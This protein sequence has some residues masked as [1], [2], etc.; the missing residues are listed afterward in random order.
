MELEK[1][2][3][4]KITVKICNKM[5]EIKT[6]SRNEI[7]NFGQSKTT[8]INRNLEKK[9]LQCQYCGKTLSSPQNLRIHERLH[10][11][12]KPYQCKYCEKK[13]PTSSVLRTHHQ[14]HSGTQKPIVE[15]NYCGKEVKNLTKHMKIHT[16]IK[17]DSFKCEIC[18]KVF[19][20]R[21][22]C[23]EHQKKHIFEKSYQCKICQKTL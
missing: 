10:S 22:D 5:D 7:E 23:K 4:Q 2:R 11:G 6:Q 3:V 19:K 14:T 1:G 18:D 15:C 17:D 21:G 8:K 16:E 9:S 13:F 20:R 12:E